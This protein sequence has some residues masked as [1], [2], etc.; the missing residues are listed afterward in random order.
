MVLSSFCGDLVLRR[1]ERWS[2]QN[3]VLDRS[4]IVKANVYTFAHSAQFASEAPNGNM[5]YK[6]SHKIMAR[7]AFCLRF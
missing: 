5:P 1:E 4:P 2:T 3:P 6:N 7:E